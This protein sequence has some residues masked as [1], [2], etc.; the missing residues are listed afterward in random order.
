MVV[1]YLKEKPGTVGEADPERAKMAVMNC[2]MRGV[3]QLEVKE[4][5]A[6]LDRGLV[7]VLSRKV[8]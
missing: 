1:Q 3:R 8:G 6:K 2:W 4:N 7:K 5:G